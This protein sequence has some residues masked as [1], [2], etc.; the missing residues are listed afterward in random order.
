MTPETLK[1]FVRTDHV[2]AIDRTELINS[3][4]PL[5]ET[6]EK[7][8]FNTDSGNRAWR[9]ILDNINDGTYNYVSEDEARLR[10]VDILSRIIREDKAEMQQ[11]LGF[12]FVKKLKERKRY[13][14]YEREVKRL[15]ELSHSIFPIE[16]SND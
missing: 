5:T 10:V 4:S 14:A 6:Q 11:L 9:T 12:G 13:E 1:A 2:D 16:D 15:Q 3:P 7:E 8:K